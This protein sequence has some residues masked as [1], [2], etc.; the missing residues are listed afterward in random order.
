MADAF[1]PNLNLTKPEVG[2]S[3]DTWGTKL[4]ADLDALDAVFAAAGSGTSVGL[5][6]GSGKTLKV[7]GTADLDTSV[8]INESGADKDLRVEGDTDANLFFTDASTDRVGVGTNTPDAKFTVNGVG[9]FGAGAAATPSVAATGDL[10]TGFW[11]PAADTLAASTAGTERFRINSSGNIGINS[12]NP[13]SGRLVIQGTSVSVSQGLR[14]ASDSVDARFLGE[15]ASIGAAISGTFSN[16]NYL[17]YTNSVE[18]GSFDSN[19]RFYVNTSQ[20]FNNGVIG[21][22]MDN[23]SNGIEVFWNS[24]G[25][26][27]HY[28]VRNPNGFLGGIQSN[29]STVSYVNLS[30]KRLKTNLKEL[31]GAGERLDALKVYEF[32]LVKG[33]KGKGV[34]AQDAYLIDPYPITIGSGDD[35]NVNDP[36][37]MPW[38]ADYSKYVPDLLAVV[39]ELR[40]EVAKLKTEVNALKNTA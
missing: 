13:Q 21:I 33:G 25:A 40:Q 39:K 36:A 15:S 35:I 3:T 4:N 8:V 11:F 29:G 10:N 23:Y 17:F 37:F 32:D 12:S 18:R 34:L 9:A 19:G 27:Y 6:V 2:A 22:N 26:I 7:T 31:A 5:N 1:T 38:G 14:F 30:D 16:H 20:I 28:L 24:T